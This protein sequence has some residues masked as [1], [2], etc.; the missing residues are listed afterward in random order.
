MLCSRGS[1]AMLPV[2]TSKMMPKTLSTLSKVLVANGVSGVD[3][4]RLVGVVDSNTTH[5]LPSVLT[6]KGVAEA[7][8]TG[9][10]QEGTTNTIL[11]ARQTRMTLQTLLSCWPK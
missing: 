7:M 5:P 8:P 4:E 10:A 6:M 1:I 2:N 3:V 9:E 11:P